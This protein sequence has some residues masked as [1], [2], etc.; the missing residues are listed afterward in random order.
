MGW[1]KQPFFK[2]KTKLSFMPTGP[3]GGVERRGIG[4]GAQELSVLTLHSKRSS[5]GN[6]GCRQN[7]SGSTLTYCDTLVC[8]PEHREVQLLICITRITRAIGRVG[9][10]DNLLVSCVGPG[11]NIGDAP[12]GC[13]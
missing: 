9:R 4:N 8:L 1:R 6:S 5:R 12:P 2:K 7:T 11:I 3:E 13:A 10:D